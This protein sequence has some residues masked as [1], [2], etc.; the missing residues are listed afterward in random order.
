M[1]NLVSLQPLSVINNNICEAYGCD[2]RAITQIE[3]QVGKLGTIPLNLCIA[4]VSLFKVN[5]DKNRE[6]F[7]NPN[8]MS[9]GISHQPTEER[10]A[11]SKL[12][13]KRTTLTELL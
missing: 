4:C 2:N 12:V 3:V 13:P 5:Q 6:L 1:N 8:V 7:K 11:Q 9:G 10:P